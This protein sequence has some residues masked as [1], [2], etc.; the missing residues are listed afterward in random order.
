M[1]NKKT[2]IQRRLVVSKKNYLFAVIILFS[3]SVALAGLSMPKKIE[4]EFSQ[5][6]GSTVIHTI[7]SGGMLQVILYCGKSP[8]KTVFDYYKNKSSLAGWVVIMEIKNPDTYQLM[9][10][11]NGLDGMIAVA[12]ENGET[13]AILSISE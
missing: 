13:S 6:P 1:D 3:Y 8:I 4:S 7:D 12:D 5:Y 2:I 10:N 9:L 11:K